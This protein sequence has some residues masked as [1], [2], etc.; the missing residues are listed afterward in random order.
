M[1]ARRLLERFGRAPT[2]VLRRIGAGTLFVSLAALGA[3]LAVSYTASANDVGTSA[4]GLV[5]LSVLTETGAGSTE[6][7]T[8]DAG[9]TSDAEPTTTQEAPPPAPP[10][11]TTIA[12]ATTA[13]AP[14]E[15]PPAATVTD[16]DP[17]IGGS[18]PPPP[19][20]AAVLP[21]KHKA[22]P[23]ETGEGAHAIVWIHVTLP[24]PTPPAHRL[25]PAFA[26][27]LRKISRAA[28]VRWSLV[29]GVVRARGGAS[30]RPASAT[31]LLRIAHRLAKLNAN[32]HPWGAMVA[33]AHGRHE[34]ASQALALA[35]Y[36]RAAGLRALVHG[37]EWAK[38][39]LERRIL[40]DPRIDI[41]PGGRVDIALHRIDVRVLVL[42]RYLRV[43][44]KQVTVSSLFS[45][46]RYYARP[47]VVSAHMYGLAADIARV[48]NTPI[49]RHQQ[50]GGITERAVKAILR[51]PSEL[52]PQ[53]VISLL[54]LGG[55]SFPLAD[56]YDH[57]HVGF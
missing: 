41:Y 7:A 38:P 4:S 14:A 37:L 19:P 5:D 12:E 1:R 2:F 35:R 44:F 31:E 33:M 30:R 18:A 8:T 51:L 36:D 48:G 49:D 26:R 50:A 11:T 28:G 22:R 56:H 53:Q 24:D 52:Q 15:D 43:T 23:A 42:I 17:P 21:T 3:F 6:E 46:H 47:G 25:D 45:G 54:G 32:R 55:P 10:E 57:I 40:R 39:R 13:E 27:S 20:A 9:T 29:L 16:P 34:L